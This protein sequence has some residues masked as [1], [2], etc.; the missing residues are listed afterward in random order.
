MS[1][2]AELSRTIDQI[3][4]AYRAH[5]P[6]ICAQIFESEYIICF[7]YR[8]TADAGKPTWDDPGWAA[9]YDVKFTSL[10][11]DMGGGKISPALE[12]P[13]WLAKHCQF[14]LDESEATQEECDR[15]ESEW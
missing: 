8:K 5:G 2:A 4:L 15:Q 11:E 1:T 3:G 7:E 14:Y 12:C 13:E 6:N 9:E 10:H